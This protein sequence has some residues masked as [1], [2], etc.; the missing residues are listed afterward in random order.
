MCISVHLLYLA[1]SCIISKYERILILK[2]CFTI[3]CFGSLEKEKKS[4]QCW[5]FLKPDDFA[6]SWS[7]DHCVFMSFLTSIKS[8][9][10]NE[11]LKVLEHKVS[12]EQLTQIYFRTFLNIKHKLEI[13]FYTFKR[14]TDV[15]NKYLTFTFRRKRIPNFEVGG[16]FN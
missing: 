9:W 12:P 4:L 13:D 14:N 10:E 3:W 16:N 8:W 11:C 7:H 2:G 5:W 6:V 15:L 1:L